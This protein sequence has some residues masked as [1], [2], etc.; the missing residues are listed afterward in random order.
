M[1]NLAFADSFARCCKLASQ[2]FAPNPL[3]VNIV[4]SLAAVNLFYLSCPGQCNISFWLFLHHST[5]MGLDP[6]HHLVLIRTQNPRMIVPTK[7]VSRENDG[8]SHFWL[9]SAKSFGH[10]SSP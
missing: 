5:K 1:F 8:Q 4:L 3:S 7:I 2:P 6:H 9:H 10:M